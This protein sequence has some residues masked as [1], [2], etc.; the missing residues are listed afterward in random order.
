MRL[1]SASAA[2]TMRRRERSTWSLSSVASAATSRKRRL[3]SRT[4]IPIGIEWPASPATM[5]ASSIRVVDVVEDACVVAGDTEHADDA[6]H[7]RARDEEPRQDRAVQQRRGQ[8]QRQHDREHHHRQQPR[9]QHHNCDRDHPVAERD[10]QRARYR[11]H[12]RRRPA[13]RPSAAQHGRAG[14]GTARRRRCR[15]STPGAGRARDPAASRTLQRSS[16]MNSRTPP[17]RVRDPPVVPSSSAM[18]A[19]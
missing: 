6:E 4:M 12:R 17:V 8:H 16:T 1:R 2:P 7:H 11:A 19:R 15:R 18:G 14:T 9:E 5:T 13:A 10:D 3:V